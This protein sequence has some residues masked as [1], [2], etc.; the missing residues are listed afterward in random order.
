[1]DAMRLMILAGALTGALG[2]LAP[3]PGAAGELAGVTLPDQIAVEGRFLVLNGMG[4]REATIF[5]VDVYVA[6]LYLEARSSDAG[7]IIAADDTKRLILRFVRDVSRDD[8][9][10]AWTEGF[11]KSAGP[12]LG[13]LGDRVATLNAWMADLRRGDTMTFTQLPG[14]GVAVAINDEVKGAIPGA[15]FARALWGIWLGAAPPN[16]GLKRGLLGR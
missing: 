4:L 7:R 16:T 9:A 6:G 12:G 13:A 8:L 10:G 14:R 2:A 1:M 5:R 11:Q 3:A 15:D